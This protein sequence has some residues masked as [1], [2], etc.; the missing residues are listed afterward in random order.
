MNKLFPLYDDL[1]A[2]CKA[3]MSMG[4]SVFRGTCDGISDHDAEGS[5]DDV[6][7]IDW[8]ASE[9]EGLDFYDIP[10]CKTFYDCII[11]WALTCHFL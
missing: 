10:V 2:L 9:E 1:V 7:R 4:A 3:V 11:L 8:V 5:E 6:D